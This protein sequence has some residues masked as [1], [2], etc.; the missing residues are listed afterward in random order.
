[1]EHEPSKQAFNQLAMGT[2]VIF[3]STFF[4]PQMGIH[5]RYWNQQKTYQAVPCLVPS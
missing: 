1:V 2:L 5:V 3:R 4:A